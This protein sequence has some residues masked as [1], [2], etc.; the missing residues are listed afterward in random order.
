MKYCLAI[1]FSV[2]ALGQA[3]ITITV[4]GETNTSITIQPEGF[5]G[6]EN[7]MESQVLTFPGAPVTLT[8]ATT[9]N[10]TTFALSSIPSGVGVVNGVMIGGEVSQ[11]SA[12]SGNNLTVQRAR[13]ATTA[14]AS[15]SGTP[16][17]FITAGKGGTLIAYLLSQWLTTNLPV[18]PGPIISAAQST[19]ATQ[20]GTI[21]TTIAGVA[22]IAP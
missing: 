7:A 5:S 19:I 16:V 18:Y 6:I 12:I 3:T 17:K 9:T 21:Q 2:F 8:S 10:S 22:T 14:V 20:N 1:I 4:P 13:L 15:A 11:I